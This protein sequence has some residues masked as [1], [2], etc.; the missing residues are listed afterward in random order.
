VRLDV[1]EDRAFTLLTESRES[2]GGEETLYLPNGVYYWRAHPS[3]EAAAETAR[4][5]ADGK[6]SVIYAPPPLL[7]HPAPGGRFSFRTP[8]PG[9]RFQWQALEGASAYLIEVFSSPA[10]EAP[11]FSAS[12]QPAGGDTVSIVQSGLSAGEYSWRVTPVYPQGYAGTAQTSAASSFTIEQAAFLPAPQAK[13]QA[14]TVYLE[15]P[16]QDTYLT[17][18]QEEEAA[19]YTFLLSRQEDLGSPLIR[20]Q[21]LDNYHVLNAR[22]EGLE[23][24]RYYWGVSQTGIEGN[25][26][27]FSRARIIV[28]TA[29]APPERAALTENTPPTEAR[30]P[31]PEQAASVTPAPEQAASTAPAPEQAAPERAA[32]ETSA[33]KAPEQAPPETPVAAAPGRTAGTEARPPA[34]VAKARPPAPAAEQPAPKAPE[35]PPARPEQAARTEARPPAPVPEQPPPKAPETPP[36]RPEQAART[37]ARP[38]T[39]AAEETP[40]APAPRPVIVR[41][42]PAPRNLRP[43]AGY[44]LN[45][46]IILRDKRMVFSWEQVPGAAGYT[47]VLYQGEGGTSREILRQT[48]LAVPSFTLTDLKVLDA[49][50]FVWQVEAEGGEHGSEA[51]LSRFRVSLSEIEA[52]ESRESG[53]MFG[54]D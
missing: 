35:T 46:E 40:P 34:P 16:R 6:L 13:E 28:V 41:P 11:L 4:R 54:R 53:V 49:G 9:I 39:P 23:P 5:G 19:Y 8:R 14:E 44:V 43:E 20:K 17:W 47:F 51:A 2:S 10:P 32:S 12:V 38:S 3:S 22:E 52:P 45:E 7:Y 42:L 15:D 50:E 26:S 27:A 24:G 48:A 1:A 30:P 33:P 31:V 29:G 37:E 25:D 21:K 36:A 18:N